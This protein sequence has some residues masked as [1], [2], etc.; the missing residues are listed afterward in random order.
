MFGS[1]E[2]KNLQDWSPDGQHILF[3]S[4]PPE[5]GRDLWAWPISGD[6]ELIAVANTDSEETSG[7][8]SPA[9]SLVAYVS[10]ETG[11]P[12]IYVQRFPEAGRRIPV[13][14][15][16]PGER[17]SGPVWR[18]DGQELFYVAPD[19]YLTAVPITL[20]G[21]EAVAGPSRQLFLMPPRASFDVSPDGQRFLVNMV[22]EDDSYATLSFNWQPE[23][24]Q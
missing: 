3:E 8:F 16:R 23:E 1:S 13:G 12:E 21:A 5:A 17:I 11:R 2:F 18:G 22:I 19:G 15:V 7:R 9:G 24:D 20:E 4:Q 10:N 14:P 6:G